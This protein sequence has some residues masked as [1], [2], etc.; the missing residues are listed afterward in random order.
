M[1]S[2]T[3]APTGSGVVIDARVFRD[4]LGHYPTGVVAVTGVDDDGAPLAMVVGTFNS[5]SLEP[6]LVSFMPMKTSGTYETLRRSTSLCIN[7]LAHDQQLE[8]RILA[9]RDPEKFSKVAWSMSRH[10]VPMLDGAV[11]LIHCGIAQEIDAGDHYIVLCDVRDVE[12]TRPVTPLLFFQGGY[13]GFSATTSAAHVDADLIS[14]VRV[15]E[16]ARA[17]L[18]D[19]A[20]R[21]DCEAVALVQINDHDQ[22]IGAAART[23]A[24]STHERLGVRMPLIPP[25][26]DV[27]VAWNAEQ[28]EKWLARIFPPEP[29]VIESYRAR[30]EAVRER[31]YTAHVVPEGREEDH[32]AFTAA[33]HEY[34]LGQLTPAR[35]RAVRTAM[36]AAA[37]FYTTDPIADDALARVV[38]LTVPVFDPT[39]DSDMN[40]GLVLRLS[41]EA[42]TMNG[43][44]VRERIGA[45]QA[46]A[47]QVGEALSGAHTE[48][49]ERYLASGLRGR[50]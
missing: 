6:P 22:T 31:G 34:A 33:L 36:S 27:S 50:G 26:G 10:G 19:L 17:Q 5:V 7:V 35:D 16:A 40:S 39:A 28:A 9:Q 32:A 25:L 12:V 13:G 11:A 3:I 30:L 37:D 14:A 24:V 41:F 42:A 48:D 20:E 45:L 47:S 1:I 49:F 43:V 18:T 8:T 23:S 15:A 46:A 4:V 38:S 2:E 21:F 29:A 44:E